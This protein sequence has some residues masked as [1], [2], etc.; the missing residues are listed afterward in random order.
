MFLKLL[1]ISII[2]ISIAL[3][4]LAIKMFVL[5][6]GELKKQCGSVDPKTG[7][8]LSCSCGSEEK[9]KCE[10]EAVKA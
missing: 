8:R 10:N 9:V 7:N 3:A 5:K 6:G 2:L 1:L 4:G